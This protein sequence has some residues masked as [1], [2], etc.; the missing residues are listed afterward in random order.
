MQLLRQDDIILLRQLGVPLGKS[1]LNNGAHLHPQSVAKEIQCKS[2]VER[3]KGDGNEER[4]RSTYITSSVRGQKKSVT[5]R[6]TRE[7][8]KFGSCVE[9]K[10]TQTIWKEGD[11]AW[12]KIKL[13]RHV[14]L[15]HSEQ[16]LWCPSRRAR[17]V[18]D[19]RI[20]KAHVL[21]LRLLMLGR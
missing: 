12:K 4:K 15:V 18:R 16:K 13:G 10:N 14:Y 21:L 17:T 11:E 5:E 19:H 2:G 3:G 6:H 20:A 9:E 8:A 7:N 1:L